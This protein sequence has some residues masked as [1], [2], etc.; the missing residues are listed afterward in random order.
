MFQR[1]L[2]ILRPARLI[3]YTWWDYDEYIDDLSLGAEKH[4]NTDA[5]AT[6]AVGRKQIP[7]WHRTFRSDGRTQAQFLRT[8]HPERKKRDDFVKAVVDWVTETGSARQAEP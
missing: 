2:E 7:W 1:E 5:D 6:R 8:A 4:D 3:F